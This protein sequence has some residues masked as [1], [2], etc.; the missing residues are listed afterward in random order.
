M[1]NGT[2]V[3][4]PNAL[5]PP[6]AMVD[7]TT[8]TA[9]RARAYLDDWVP[10]NI[11]TH[12]Y[13][14][15]NDVIRVPDRPAGF[16]TSWGGAPAV[17]YGMDPEV[18]DDPDYTSDLLAG[19][20]EI[21][22]LSINA[23]I[24][25][26]FG[27]SGLY[28]RTQD[29]NFEIGA[30]AELIL[31]DGSS[32][33]QIDAGFKIQGGASRNPNRSPKH[34]MSLRFRD[35]YGEG[36]LRYP[37]FEDSPV[38]AFDSL[39]LRAM[40]N[41]SWIHWNPSQRPRGTLI[42]DQFMRDSLLDMGQADA[43]RGTYMHVYLDGLYW[44]VFNVH[45]RAEA[46]HYEAYNGGDSAVLDALNGGTAND[47]NL[48]SYNAMKA[49][50][51]TQD[52]EEIQ[53]VLDVDN[54]IDFTIMQRYGSNNDLKADGNW[55]AAGGGPDNL[56]WRF[57]SW[58]GERILEGVNEGGPGGTPDPPN[59]L[60][61]LTQIE[62]FRVR[63]ADRVQMHFFNGGALTPDSVANRWNARVDE[64]TNA[65]VGESARWGDY[66]RDVHVDGP[67]TLFTRDDHWFPEINRLRNTYFP[68]R[69]DIVIGQYENLGLYPSV[70]APSFTIGGAAQFGGEISSGDS[71]G[72]Q[73]TG[74]V[75]YY[76]LDGTD[77][78]AEGGDPS[79]LAFSQPISLTESTTVNARVRA[80][81]GS[82][83]ALVTA[84]FVV[85]PASDA[86]VISEINYNP[87]GPTAA[88]TAIIPNLSSDDFEFIEVLN[89]SST[90]INLLDMQLTDGVQFT[91]PDVSLAAGDRAVVVEDMAAFAV[92]YGDSANV[93]GQWT[94]G[95]ANGG[96]NIALSDGIG[97]TVFEFEYSDS[98]PWPERADG[99]GGTLVLAD[100][101]N[102]TADL[103]GKPYSWRGGSEFGRY[104]RSRLGRSF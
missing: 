30:S 10:T 53:K 92:R 102:I 77:P 45:E 74:G 66:R 44:G 47:G 84:T 8:T 4:A 18:V 38:N 93:V 9:I 52:W 62:E 34:S 79:G 6:V 24:A 73:G 3:A 83:S 59:I 72:I 103:L 33:F 49:T 71:L 51:A 91:F 13:V 43:Q 19:L 96:E 90:T 63:F 67:A 27:S 94:G 32:G 35:E 36:K 28:S 39:Q 48:D 82:W 31:P 7:V 100:E 58:D 70:D 78:R 101:A 22:T 98:D 26:I 87:H 68:Q 15:L 1:T 25:D 50:V 60:S 61:T 76:T 104:P 99:A 46:N 54:Y 14:Y 40:Y 23:D 69:T 80:G 2:Q 95:L 89:T 12:S 64:L 88:E 17:D 65:I 85:V 86:V 42:R 21:P 56:P 16:P 97:N 75:V 5:M 41:N 57:Y 29:S 55:R 81:D 20:R 11:D 37:V